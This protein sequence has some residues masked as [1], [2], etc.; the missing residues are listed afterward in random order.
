MSSYIKEAHKFLE[1]NT[2]NSS[3]N[4]GISIKAIKLKVLGTAFYL[5]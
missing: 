1:H 2:E 5:S 3:A 4:A